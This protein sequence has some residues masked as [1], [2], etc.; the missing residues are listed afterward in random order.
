M[1]SDAER[2][3]IEEELSHYP[4]KQAGCVEALKVV[5]R[6]RGWVSD[7]N[8]KSVAALLGMTSDELD[9]VATFYNLILRKPVGRHVIFLCDSI[10]CWVCGCDAMR[11]SLQ[12]LLGISMG[13]TTPDGRFTL[14][15]IVCL[16]ACDHAPTMMVNDDLHEDL[17]IEK[18][19]RVLEQYP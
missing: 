1:L 4:D 19:D 15:P 6:H 14:L 12:S 13:E 18:V 17:T 11:K 9:S 7:E 3:E 5:Q 8:L 16:G 2:A 10:S